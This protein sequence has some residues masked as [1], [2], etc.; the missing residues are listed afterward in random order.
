[1]AEAFNNNQRGRFGSKLNW[2]GGRKGNSSK[3]SKSQTPSLPNSK[4][5]TGQEDFSVAPDSSRFEGNAPLGS[6]FNNGYILEDGQMIAIERINFKESNPSKYA[7]DVIKVQV[8]DHFD[9][10]KEGEEAD[11]DQIKNN[12]LLA[13]EE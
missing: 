6:A 13:L 5:Q 1:M 11:F 2:G 12:F 4:P 8:K 10:L 3:N 9:G 7:F